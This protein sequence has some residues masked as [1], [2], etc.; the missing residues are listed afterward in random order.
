M[1]VFDTLGHDP[2]A[3]RMGELDGGAHKGEVTALVGLAQPGDEAAVEV[4]FADGEA[5]EIGERGEAGAEVV[6]RDDEAE[7]VE[8]LDR[9]LGALEVGDRG[10]LGHL[11]DECA[12][13]QPVLRRSRSTRSGKSGS[14]R[15]EA[16]MFTETARSHRRRARS[17]TATSPHRGRARSARP[18]ARRLRRAR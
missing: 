2:Q 8:L 10:G 13:T 12:G 6:D 17:S 14:R 15:S 9:E 18:S 11:E 4:Q 3:E 5:A 7:I 1:V 16:E